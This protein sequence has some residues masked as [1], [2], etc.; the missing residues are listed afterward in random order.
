MKTPALAAIT[1]TLVLAAVPTVS[2]ANLVYDFSFTDESGNS[3]TGEI[4][5]PDDPINATVAATSVFID[6]AS[7]PFPY[8]L[9][10]DTINNMP[11]NMK[12]FNSFTFTNGKLTDYIYSASQEINDTPNGLV[13]DLQFFSPNNGGGALLFSWENGG[14]SIG[15]DNS[16]TLTQVS[17]REIPEPSTWAMLLLG[18]GG[19]GLAC[20][21]SSRRTA[22]R[23]AQ[24]HL[25]RA[26]LPG[27]G[28]CSHEVRFLRRRSER[29]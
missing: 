28:P 3:V 23:P 26:T 29:A 27:A 21:R 13:Y 19:L 18:F 12:G 16:P 24:A 8:P 15:T 1:A 10:Y 14:E 2:R 25:P 17:A 5:L 4:D 6:S 7:I 9:P 11:G 22:A 20:Y